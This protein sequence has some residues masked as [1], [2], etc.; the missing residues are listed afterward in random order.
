MNY[1]VHP[2]NWS[3]KEQQGT[4]G[5]LSLLETLRSL[6]VRD[7]NLHLFVASGE[8]DVAT[9][10]F[11]TKYNMS[12]LQLPPALRKN[13]EQHIYNGG[14]MMYL[15]EKILIQMNDDIRRFIQKSE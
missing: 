3:L 9:P 14:H 6:L 2:W 7:P 5:Y 12:H 1:S 15:N 4:P 10:Y 11:A 13:V 8:F